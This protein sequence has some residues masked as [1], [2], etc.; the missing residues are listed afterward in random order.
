MTAAGQNDRLSELLKGE[1]WEEPI[2]RP[3]GR[4]REDV[5]LAALED[6]M[7]DA[8]NQHEAEAKKS[9]QVTRAASP[10]QSLCSQPRVSSHAGWHRHGSR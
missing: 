1:K 7:R 2:A 5:L 3:K 9:E 4:A 10:P 6:V 8:R